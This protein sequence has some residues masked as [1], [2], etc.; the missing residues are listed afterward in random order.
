MAL[1][2]GR[3]NR[4]DSK[5]KVKNGS[6]PSERLRFSKGDYRRKE[7]FNYHVHRHENPNKDW[8]GCK[9]LSISM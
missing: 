5:V 7:A 3:I 8:L 4:Y 9:A 6:Q 2:S 1:E